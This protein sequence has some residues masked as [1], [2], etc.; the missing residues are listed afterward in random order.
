MKLKSGP[1]FVLISCLLLP[2]M[3]VYADEIDKDRPMHLIADSA[4]TVLI[5]TKL[6][7]EHLPSLKDIKVDTDDKGV[8]WLSG[9]ADNQTA[10]NRAESIA[11]DT[12]GVRAVKNQISVKSVN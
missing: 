4:I 3:G 8:V 11:R 2:A 1:T 9:N 12:E 7:A 5:K 10:I 6:A